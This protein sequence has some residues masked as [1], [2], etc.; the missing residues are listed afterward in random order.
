M[1]TN[2]IKNLTTNNTNEDTNKED[3]K[4]S[5]VNIRDIRGNI[6][7]QEESTNETNIIYKEECY[8]IY[9][10][11]YIVHNKL[12]N[13]FLES[14]YQEALEIEFRKDK[15]PF[16][17][18][19]MIRIYYD[20]KPLTQFFKADIVCYDKIL[21]ELKAV[22]KINNEHKAQLINYLTATKIK[23]GLLVNFG[24]HPKVEICRI[25]H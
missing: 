12:G 22:T 2:N 16:E 17:S 21:L 24:T 25:V 11:I 8:K 19:K 1:K 6:I 23:L 14:V 9:H 4:D 7:D 15:I 3:N 20:D 18:Q 5:F 13:G 10:C